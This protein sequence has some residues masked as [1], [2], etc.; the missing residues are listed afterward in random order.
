MKP[1]GRAALKTRLVVVVHRRMPL[2]NL[3]AGK[4]HTHASC[5]AAVIKATL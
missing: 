1:V 5:L 2:L 3:G 4:T